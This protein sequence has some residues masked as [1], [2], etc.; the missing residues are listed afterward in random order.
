MMTE[1]PTLTIRPLNPDDPMVLYHHYPGQVSRQDAYIALDLDNGT[2]W[3]DWDAEIGNAVPES[4]WHNRV[5]RYPIPPVQPATANALMQEI[6]PLAQRVLDG[7]WIEWDGSNHVGHLNAHAQSAE[8]EMELIL[9]EVESDVHVWEASDWLNP[10]ES[11]IRAALRDGTTVD[12]L[13]DE[14]QGDGRAEETPFVPDLQ[15]YLEMVQRN[16]EDE[17]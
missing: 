14:Y 17:D 2:M 15:E 6:A 8:E 3:A 11:D 5:I 10:V 7:S 1:T 9:R 4:V 16:L 13:Y 12:A